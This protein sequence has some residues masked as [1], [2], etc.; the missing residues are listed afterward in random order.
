M[1]SVS[2]GWRE[3]G[4]GSLPAPMAGHNVVVHENCLY[5]VDGSDCYMYNIRERR[6]V[7]ETP[8]HTRENYKTGGGGLARYHCNLSPRVGEGVHYHLSLSP[9]GPGPGGCVTQWVIYEQPFQV[10]IYN[11][12]SGGSLVMQWWLSTWTV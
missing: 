10:M 6:V 9:M 4:V 5:I 8:P 7:E 11:F 12:I 2:S 1:Y 3:V